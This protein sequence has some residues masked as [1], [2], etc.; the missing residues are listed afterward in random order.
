MTSYS[1]LPQSFPSTKSLL[2]SVRC[3]WQRFQEFAREKESLQAKP[4][5]SGSHHQQENWGS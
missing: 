5:Q 3:S 4:V 2:K 1:L